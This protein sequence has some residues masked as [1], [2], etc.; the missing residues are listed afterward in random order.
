MARA[1]HNLFLIFTAFCVLA[2]GS[3][4][5]WQIW[6][7]PSLRADAR[8]PRLRYEAPARR[9]GILSADGEV[10]VQSVRASD[11]RW[12]RVYTAY[13]GLAQTLGYVSPRY[14]VSGLEA[15]YDGH[16]RGVEP[17][18]RAMA[19]VA[20]LRG[21]GGGSPY[22]RTTIRSSVQAVAER[23]MAGR[24]G[25]L[26]A[27]D[28]RTG[29]ILA[30]VSLPGFAPGEVEPAWD[31]LVARADSPLL[32][33]ALSGLYP[34]G[35]VFKPVVALAALEAAKTHP[36]EVFR[37]TG[38]RQVDGQVITDLNGAVH[39]RISLAEAMRVS[40]NYVF[41]GLAMRLSPGALAGATR[42]YGVLAPAAVGLPSAA[43]RFPAAGD[44]RQ[45]DLAELGIGQ[46]S[47]LVTPLGLA[48]FAATLARGGVRV[49]PR[50]VERLGVSGGLEWA[51]RWRAWRA[52]PR[53][54]AAEAAAEVGEMLAGVVRSGTGW[55]AALPGAGVAGKTGSAENPHGPPHAWFIGYAPAERP[56]VAVAVVIENGGLGGEVAA[57][58]AREV[59]A[60]ALK[61]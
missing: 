4:A 40:C 12:V 61:H 31:R 1:V 18:T 22:V 7:G 37:C 21:G 47:L 55:R 46:G 32:N 38:R 36:A 20:S 39:G 26:V 14:G 48:R 56:Q 57:P 9:G 33:R 34:P 11:G 2:V 16:L 29:A 25:A 8:N 15:A 27:V 41:S 52:A 54:V 51:P 5:Y 43:G 30:L 53:V 44:L 49:E 60:A 10:L 35:S 23:W 59:I 45:R 13:P 17:V 19:L 3:A 50:L 6:R 58:V 24:R 28:P 42:R